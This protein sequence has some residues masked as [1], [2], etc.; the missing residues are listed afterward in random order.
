[1]NNKIKKFVKTIIIAAMCI[2]PSCS[3]YLDIVPD[4]TLTLDDVFTVKQEAYNALAKLYY[5]MPPDPSA[6]Y[7]TYML[8]DEYLS[9]R[10]YLFSFQ[11]HI[12]MR[13]LNTSTDPIMGMWAGTHAGTPMYRAINSAHVFI[14]NID[15]VTDMS[16]V[17]K[18]DWKAQAKFML[19]YYSFLLLQQ[20][21]PIVLK[22]KETANTDMGEEL[23]PHRAKIEDCFDFILRYMNEAIPD[24]EEQRP[25][26]DLGQIDRVGAAAI[27]A[28][29]LVYRASPF[30][31]GNSEFYGAFL[32][33]ENEH[34]F[35]QTYDKEKWKEAIDAIEEAL[36][37]AKQNGKELYTYGKSVYSYDREDFAK[38]PD[39]MKT[40]YDLTML[41]PDPWNK[42]LLWG[43]SN[44]VAV[45]DGATWDYVMTSSTQIELRAGIGPPGSIIGNMGGAYHWIGGTYKMLERF[46]T[47]NGLPIDEDRT[48]SR[49]SMLD[50]VNTPGN[51]ELAYEEVRGY[52]QPGVQT[53][54]MYLN[55]EPRFYADMGITG[56]YWRSHNIRIP[57]MFYAGTHGSSTNGP[58]RFDTGIGVQKLVHPEST[59]GSYQRM[60]RTPFPIIRL[61]DLYLMKAEALNEYLDAPAQEVYDAVNLVRKRA[62]IPNVETVWSDA[63]LAKTVNKHKTKEGM[64]DIILQERSIELAFEGRYFFDMCRYKK[65]HLE[66]TDN[67]MGWNYFGTDATTFFVLEQKQDRIFTIR[68]YMWPI[69]ISEL[70]INSNLIQNPGW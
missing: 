40:L 19:A 14:A 64:R 1:M 69:P 24:L 50:L 34:F 6:N 18:A 2:F 58:R 33:H 7:T 22:E 31:N 61:A 5:Y 66:Y 68:D 52:L 21:G 16:D 23:F 27:K 45:R 62:G 11:Y 30:Y 47:K 54:R 56:G 36:N 51:E 63:T 26:A 4:N 65:A 57:T 15:K 39:R 8:G 53:L 46:Y 42:E 37:L 43:E 70:N 48:F 60:V 12:V 55:R 10:E 32:N 49:S 59:A 44:I 29:V 17:E 25:A 13:G 28:R 41:F 9:T 20:T 38:Q 35:P 3:D 67:I